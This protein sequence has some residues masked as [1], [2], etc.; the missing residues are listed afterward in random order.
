MEII[1]LDKIGSKGGGKAYG[2]C[3]LINAK[4]EV[5]IGF[6]VCDSL[7]FSDEN[8]GDLNS[9]LKNFDKNLK[10]AV[11]SS[12]SDEDGNFKSFAG[13]FE[14]VLNVN[15]NIDDVVNAINK[16]N[17]SAN[18]FIAQNYSNNKVKMNIIIQQM[19]NPKISGI[20]FTSSVDTKGEKCALFEYV[21]GTGEKLVSGK[22]NSNRIIVG[23][24]DGVL[25]YNHVILNGKLI[26]FD[27]FNNVCNLV[28]QAITSYKD[29]LD[30]EWCIDK[31]GKG[32]LLQARPITKD[33][34]I[35]KNNSN[36]FTNTIVASKGLVEAETYVI[37][38]NLDFKTV[39]KEIKDFPDG[40]ILVC[41]Y[42]ETYYLPAMKKAKGIITNTGSALCHAAIVSRE[43]DIPCIVGYD[44]ATKLF[45][46]GTRIKLDANNNVISIP[47]KDFY[48]SKDYK[49]NFGELDCF[50]N[51]LSIVIDDVK[52]F[53]E[54][55]FDGTYIHKPNCID[56]NII[57]KIEMFVR[58]NFNQSPSYSS[59]ENKYLWIKEIQRFKKLPYFIDYFNRIKKCSKIFDEKELIDIQHELINIV[60]KLLLYK[61]KSNDV[62]LSLFID[63]VVA[64]INELLDGIIPFGYP[65]Y[66]AYIQSLQLLNNENIS[67]NDLFSNIKLKNDKL[68]KIQK[69]LKIVSKIK[70]ESYQIVWDLGGNNPDY[71]E[72]RD[73]KI[74][75][76]LLNNAVLI[77]D[78]TMNVFY[79][80]YLNTYY[81]RLMR[82]IN[83]NEI[84]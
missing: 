30:I 72:E 13:I 29:N 25:D 84:Q 59:D 39:Q 4:I 77:N 38:S 68:I 26:D 1:N 34:F 20:C 24:N 81:E 8:I 54:Y 75:K 15:N 52:I 32:Y 51:F 64:S 79:D 42:T 18:S 67:F 37:N 14:T 58:K 43:L 49:L 70:D 48:I 11:R 23:Y 12:A 31:D 71:F 83:K 3:K 47:G 78:E 36:N 2:L 10:F 65:I 22:S 53:I 55:T 60:K 6:V 27:G 40:K 5:P 16:V 33:V 82:I 19:I 69:F 74:E 56:N 62:I 45:P 28:Q 41:D 73:N 21:E 66:E 46:T 80:K 61:K 44:N 35:E 9:K 76:L 7:S 17:E 50:D 63:E 57:E